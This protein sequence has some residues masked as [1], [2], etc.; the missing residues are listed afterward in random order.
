MRNRWSHVFE[1]SMQCLS[2]RVERWHPTISSTSGISIGLILSANED[3]LR[4]I[5][6][7]QGQGGGRGERRERGLFGD[8]G[9]E[10][11]K[12][13]E[14]EKEKMSKKKQLLKISFLPRFSLS[15]SSLIPQIAGCVRKSRT[16]RHDAMPCVTTHQPCM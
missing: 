13:N 10:K 6:Y 7:E 3:M 2:S 11:E 9:M 15:P 5:S 14:K 4:T 16:W 8:E 12:E 1:T